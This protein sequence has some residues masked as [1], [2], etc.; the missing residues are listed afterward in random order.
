MNGTSRPPS[1]LLSGDHRDLDERFEEFRATPP[2]QAGR[3]SELFDGFAT[4]LRRHIDV[5]ERLLFPVFGQGDSSRHLL[6]ELMLD[7]HRRIE[8]ALQKIHRQLDAGPT[9]T[10]DLEL[11]L[12]NVLWAHNAREE[13]SVYPWFDTHLSADLA[14]A[15]DRELREPAA[16]RD[17]P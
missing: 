8:E 2:S 14:R 1:R 10:E 6:V 15:V 13:E 7:E 11:E 5:E 17:L 12:L 16:N 3:R 4:D 9:S